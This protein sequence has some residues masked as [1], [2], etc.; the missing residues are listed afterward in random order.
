AGVVGLVVFV[1]IEHHAAEPILPLGLFRNRVFSVSIGANAVF[2][3]VLFAVSIYVPV[4]LQGV[5]GDSAT[6]SG[7]VLIGFSGGWVAAATRTGHA[8]T[9]TG[10]YRIFPIAGAVCVLVGVS[11]LTL[12]D[13][14]SS[15][16]IAVVFLTVA[17]AG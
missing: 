12:L 14:S 2:G 4:Y 9:R 8:I 17:G 3:A 16:A 15:H 6:V 11:L 7:L 5:R 1:V 13:S 10:R